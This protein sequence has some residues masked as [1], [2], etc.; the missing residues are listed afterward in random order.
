MKNEIIDKWGLVVMGATGVLSWLIFW[1][2]S[3][4]FIFSVMAALMAA[5]MVWMAYVVLR[6]VFFAFRK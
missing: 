2:Y 3:G 6:M 5:G 1:S 4:E